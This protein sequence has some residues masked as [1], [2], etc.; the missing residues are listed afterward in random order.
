MTAVGMVYNG[1]QKV[2]VEGLA[3][4]LEAHFNEFLIDFHYC[5]DAKKLISCD[6]HADTY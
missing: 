2:M 6:F 1:Q 4:Q 5:L 3:K